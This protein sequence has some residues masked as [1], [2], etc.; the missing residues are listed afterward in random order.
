MFPAGPLPTSRGWHTFLSPI[1][2]P[3]ERWQTLQGP[4]VRVHP[5]GV[6][7]R[8]GQGQW[9]A[10]RLRPPPPPQKRPAST[11][12][13]T[14][15]Q[16]NHVHALAASAGLLHLHPVAAIRRWL[17]P[18]HLWTRLQWGRARNIRMTSWLDLRPDSDVWSWA[19]G[20][21]QVALTEVAF[22]HVAT[23][24]G[25]EHRG[26]RLWDGREPQ[27]LYTCCYATMDSVAWNLFDFIDQRSYFFIFMALNSS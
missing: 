21:A 3:T 13:W 9:P 25:A 4:A 15:H 5:P 20:P 10:A 12:V 17:R 24:E 6:P 16:E 26:K 7:A 23:A 11:Q 2:N 19:K 18:L 27:P 14:P 8:A 22:V 1:L